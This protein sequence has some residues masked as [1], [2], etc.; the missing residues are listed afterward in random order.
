M[1]DVINIWISV[2]DYVLREFFSVN[3]FIVNY[4]KLVYEN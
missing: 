4:T 1:K 3:D 2:V